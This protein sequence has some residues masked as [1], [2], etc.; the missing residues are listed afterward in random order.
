MDARDPKP[1]IDDKLFKPLWLLWTMILPQVILVFINLRCWF[2]VQEEMSTAQKTTAFQLFAFEA[3]LLAAGLL[4]F[5]LLLILRK[6]IH[7]M[8]CVLFFLVHIAYLWL[9]TA[10][11][12]RLL[13]ESV[14]IWI[15]LPDEVLYY[16]YILMMPVIF[17]TGLRLSCISLPLNRAV[18]IS[19]TVGTLIAVPLC[20]Y[21]F[22]TVLYR[23]VWD[24]NI[25]TIIMIIL[26]VTAT[27]V[28]MMAFLRLLTYIYIWLNHY[29]AGHIVL[30]LAV[31]LAGPLGG[32]VLNKT[33]PF[34]CDFQSLSVY[35]LTVVNGL[36]LLLNFKEGTRREALGWFLRCVM[37]P[38]SLYFFLVFLPFLPLSFIAII[39]LGSG[40]LILTP[41]ALFVVHTRKILDEGRRAARLMGGTAA[42]VLFLL[43]FA[44]LPTIITA[45]AFSDRHSLMRAVDAV[46]SPDYSAK[47]IDIKTESVKRSLLKLRDM[48]EG[49]FLP[50]IST[51]YNKV[52][53]NGMVLPDYK[54][55]E[56]YL[57][58]FGEDMPKS[59]SLGE[60]G[61]SRRMSFRNMPV[62]P[63]DRNVDIREITVTQ[64][65]EGAFVRA[66]LQLM[67][68]NKGFTQSEFVG[69]IQLGRGALVSGY[70]LE[71]E[72]EKVA[73]HLFEKKAAMWVYHMIRDVTR[74]D[75]GLL[76]YKTGDLLRLSVYPFASQ[77]QRLTGIELLYPVG[78]EPSVKI[79]DVPVEIPPSPTGEPEAMLFF[80][81]KDGSAHVL[82]PEKLR[83]ALPSVRRHPY[84]HFIID[85]SAGA[86]DVFDSFEALMSNIATR[87]DNVPDCKITLANY[88]STDLTDKLASTEKIPEIM[89]SAFANSVTFKGAFCYERAIKQKLL[90]YRSVSSKVSD[91]DL[92]VP[93]FVVLKSPDGEPVSIGELS[94]FGHIVPDVKKFYIA[95]EDGSFIAKE[96]D[97]QEAVQS[98]I[99]LPDPVILLK[100]GGYIAPCVN[101]SGWACAAFSESDEKP[102]EAYDAASRRFVVL[103]SITSLS[104]ETEYAQG[105]AVW[106]KYRK[107]V[108]CPL[109][110]TAM[111]PEIVDASRDCGIMV[112]STSYIVLENS[113]QL[114]MLKRKERQGL[115][116]NQALEFD[117]FM[118]SPAP[119]VIL[120]A[121]FAYVM[122]YQLKKR[123]NVS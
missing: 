94:S 93:L 98:S 103:E 66:N 45:E 23:L 24:W 1:L 120:L 16:Q 106:E 91:N 113:A 44:I 109:I 27:V 68:T 123:N 121:P 90:E 15:L 52:V 48:K 37:Y 57:M 77:Q 65:Q 10:C 119:P 9:F 114:E 95:N 56:M 61:F 53:F 40:F 122:L 46:Y 42:F 81:A 43:G 69:D 32:L 64:T 25:P 55:N 11:L 88:E 70:W 92:M 7:L 97:G 82:V 79:N 80:K 17:Y 3:A 118:E 75:P 107:T 47:T 72:G 83:D 63:P 67:L 5:G 39:A 13:P 85:C 29:K 102:L 111:L 86:K 34:P 58:F 104:D 28:T 26:F 89:Q 74:R 71:I 54:M 99:E 76:V 14:T 12:Q 101:Y 60:L 33:I 108:Y 49:I 36:I 115:S 6:Q 35:I 22:T 110:T 2:L 41:T 19:V 4:L 59:E 105:L 116:A 18:D 38:F 84:F 73:G 96:F 87:Y 51:F 62:T 30:L 21:L 78:M 117:E 31:G 20:G 100:Y 8:I 112:P 50:F